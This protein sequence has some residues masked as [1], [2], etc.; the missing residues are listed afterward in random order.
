MK[1]RHESRHDGGM[2]QKQARPRAYPA[3][4]PATVAGFRLA[5]FPRVE[6]HL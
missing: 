5:V 6:M 4:N 1:S 2:L 3:M